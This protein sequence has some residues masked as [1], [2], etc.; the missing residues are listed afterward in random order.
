MG[1]ISKQRAAL[2]KKRMV[3]STEVVN[4]F[5]TLPKQKTSHFLTFGDI[6]PLSESP[7]ILEMLPQDQRRKWAAYIPFTSSKDSDRYGIVFYNKTFSECCVA[8]LGNNNEPSTN[9]G[10]F[11]SMFGFT[12]I[13]VKRLA[14]IHAKDL[15]NQRGIPVQSH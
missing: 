6:L 15:L 10:G 3:S 11:M 8:A 7:H 13:D 14:A 5:A 12:Y 9:E 4:L 2:K 1:R